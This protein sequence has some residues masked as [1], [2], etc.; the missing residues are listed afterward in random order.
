MNRNGA[1][2][3]VAMSSTYH[4]DPGAI[5]NV[6]DPVSGLGG[7]QVTTSDLSV[8]QC[9]DPVEPVRASSSIRTM[10]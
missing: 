7:R 10:F 8:L 6:L 3:G 5:G 4:I 9:H 1:E 2:R